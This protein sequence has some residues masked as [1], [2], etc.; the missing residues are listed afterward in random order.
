MLFFIFFL[1][2]F[3]LPK[4]CKNKKKRR[5]DKKNNISPADPSTG[6]LRPPPPPETATRWHC[7]LLINNLTADY[8]SQFCAKFNFFLISNPPDFYKWVAIRPK[9]NYV[10]F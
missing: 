7:V 9:Y 10:I 2:L 8:Y 4:S 1:W 5:N 3:E 6:L